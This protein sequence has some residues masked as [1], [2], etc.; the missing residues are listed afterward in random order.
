MAKFS[1]IGYNFSGKWDD[2]SGLLRKF[3]TDDVLKRVN[4]ESVE[5]LKNRNESS[6]LAAKRVNFKMYQQ[7]SG[8][9]VIRRRSLWRGH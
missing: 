2:V 6:L 5:L 7:N 1:K 3:S 8:S 9:S 4:R